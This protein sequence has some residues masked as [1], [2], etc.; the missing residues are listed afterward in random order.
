MSDRK[1]LS[2]VT[3]A[4]MYLEVPA[5]SSTEAVSRATRLMR[6]GDGREWRSEAP[7]ATDGRWGVR[8]T[9]PSLT[10][11]EAWRLAL[12]VAGRHDLDAE[13]MFG[14]RYEVEVAPG[15]VASDWNLDEARVRKGWD[16]LDGLG[17]GRGDGVTVG[18]IDTGLTQHP[19]I[20]RGGWE[21][22]DLTKARNLAD[23]GAGPWDPPNVGL[24]P[25]HGTGTV[26]VL[27]S[28]P[29]A[30]IQGQPGAWGVAPDVTVVPVRVSDSVLLLNDV[31]R[32]ADAVRHC[33]AVGCDVITISM[34][35]F[36]GLVLQR[37]VEEAYRAGVIVCAAA[38]NYVRRP[39]WPAS[40]ETVLGVA[41]CGPGGRGWEG[42]C[43][44]AQ[45]DVTAPGHEIWVADWS[46]GPPR[47]AVVRAGSGTSYATPTVAGAAALWLRR[48]RAELGTTRGPARVD[49]F[50]RA[51]TRTSARPVVGGVPGQWGSGRLDV[52]ALLQEP[53]SS[54]W[55]PIRAIRALRPSGVEPF[56]TFAL[57]MGEARG[58]RPI[59]R[60]RRASRVYRALTAE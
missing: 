8:L 32:V 54:G 59:D 3:F 39:V 41:A 51:L 1:P 4:G 23:A 36:P 24:T 44:G 26:G 27:F 6:E 25:F 9:G 38:G 11:K 30:Q 22:V 49:A 15:Q 29:G 52:Q 12:S 58:S 16:V 35:G 34:G 7:A 40:Y 31:A 45:V 56:H 55:S 5:G 47:Q 19:E 37:A 50:R 48:W 2:D 43:R 33:V 14:S 17:M 53:P 13:P 42:S 21:G 57:P 20:D 10:P 60:A 46:A 28:P 18:H